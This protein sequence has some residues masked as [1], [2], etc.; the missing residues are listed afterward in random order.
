MT[1]FVYIPLLALTWALG[2]ALAIFAAHYFLVVIDSTAAGSDTIVWPEEPLVDYFWKVFCLAWL[3]G[4]WM[5]P[6][7]ILGR[8]ITPDPWQRLGIAGGSFWLLFP[9]GMLSSLSA[10]SPWVP[11]FPALISRIGQRLGTALG[12]YLLSL[13]ISFAFVASCYTIMMRPETSIG[14]GALLAPVAAAAYLI[15]ARALGRLGL[16]LTFTKGG[17]NEPARGKR[18]RQKKKAETIKIGEHG[19]Q[20]A[21]KQPSEMPPMQT[22]FEGLVSGYNVQLNDRPADWEAPHAGTK[23]LD[24]EELTPIPLES[25]IPLPDTA[26]PESPN[27][28]LKEAATEMALIDR[29]RR[30]V[31]PK[32][33]WDAGLVTF[34]CERRTSKAWLLLS[35]GL[36]VFGILI[37]FLRELRPTGS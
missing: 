36:A 30:L 3:G 24:E 23:R 7:I 14:L 17:E 12:F 10:R 13:P 20:P 32:V 27:P 19:E 4:A 25:E 26:E 18:K 8:L 22:P 37:F 34:L 33:V 11:F 9:I 6:V 5:G 16:V 1:A 28:L 29:S 35:T 31:E 15:Y 21:F 2:F